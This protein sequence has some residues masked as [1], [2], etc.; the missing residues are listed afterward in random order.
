MAARGDEARRGEAEGKLVLAIDQGTTS[1]RAILFDAAGRKVATAQREIT[2]YRTTAGW[3]EH[4]AS[5]IWASVEAVVQEVLAE[6]RAAP[7]DVAAVGITNQRETTVVWDRRT[8]EP[9]ARAIVWMDTRAEGIC[10]AVAREVGGRDGLVGRTGLPLVPYFSGPKLRWML[11]NVPAVRRAADEGQALFGTVDSWLVYKLT[12][13]AVHVTDVTNASRT[14]LLNIDTLAWD[15]ELLRHF[16]V[17]RAMLPEVRSSSEEYGRCSAVAGLRGVPISGILGDQQAALFGQACFAEGDAKNTYG[18]GCFLL[19]NTGRRVRSTHGLL[20]T[21]AY[22]LGAGAAPV[23]ALEGSVAQGGSV[24]QWLRDKVRLFDSSRDIEPLA[25]SVLHE[26]AN[27]GLYLV[28]AFTGL[29]APRWR[30]DARGVLVGITGATSRAHIARAALESTAFQSL[31]LIRAMEK[32]SG[33]ACTR[34]RVDGG[35]CVNETLLQL[36]ADLARADIVRPAELETTALG[37]AYV[38]GLAVGVWTGVDQL[39]RQWKADR[40]FQPLMPADLA[41]THFRGWQRAVDRSLNLATLDA[42]GGAEG[43]KGGHRHKH[44][45]DHSSDHTIPWLSAALAGLALGIAVGYVAFRAKPR[46]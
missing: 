3:A 36:Q 5:E 16:G 7:A 40:V 8:G 1:S 41:H 4:D 18:T 9:L 21:V 29:F 11:E 39:A 45:H 12:G 2:Q 38:A 6:A 27:G 30:A 20:T 15:E 34:L 14:L 22:Q 35:M 24:V 42:D 23:Y 25:K 13:G 43:E 26:P 19:F 44:S 46:E 33:R 17:P 37:A 10:E 32:D 31:E 28:P